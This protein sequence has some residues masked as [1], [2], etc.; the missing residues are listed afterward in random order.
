MKGYKGFNNKLQ[1]TPNGKAFQYEVGETYTHNGP[2]TL[3]SKGFHFC[4]HPLDTWSYYKPL[5]GSRY[6]EVDADNVSTET[7]DDSKRVAQSL[8]VKAEVKVPALLK[9][10]VEFVFSK[11]KSSPTVSATTGNSA[12]S[13]T[14]GNYAHSATTGYYAHSATTGYSAHS[15]TTGYSAHSA[16]TGYSAHS[17]TTGD[18]AHS[19]TTGNYAHSATTGYSAHSATTGYSAQSSVAGGQCIAASLGA[20]GQAKGIKGNWLVLAEWEAGKIKAMG[21]ARVDG[22]KIKADTLYLLKDGKFVE[23]T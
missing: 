11:V 1:C 17:A 5:D 9:A 6:A 13:A 2:V 18:S 3:C 7:R 12:H 10:A 8:T 20:A 4:E 15:A 23:A 22:K 16:T 19:A 14:T 21:I